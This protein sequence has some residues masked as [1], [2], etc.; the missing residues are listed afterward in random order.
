MLGVEINEVKQTIKIFL[1][2]RCQAL[3]GFALGNPIL[4]QV[5]LK[6]KRNPNTL[7]Y[8]NLMFRVLIL[9]L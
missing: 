4:E 3:K 9:L 6:N 5:R 2:K 7:V 8:G 1:K